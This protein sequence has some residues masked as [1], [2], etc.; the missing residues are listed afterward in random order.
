MKRPSEHI[1]HSLNYLKNSKKFK[2]KLLAVEVEKCLVELFGPI[3]N[4]YLTRVR[5]TGD[6]LHLYINSSTFKH[7]LYHDK[8]KLMDKLHEKIGFAAFT[9][10]QVH[11]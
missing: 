10:V 5:V 9:D 11:G 1:S 3:I 8:L 4:Q 7:E 6:I 2:S